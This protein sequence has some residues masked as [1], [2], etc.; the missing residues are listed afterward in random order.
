MV[1]GEEGRF[2]TLPDVVGATVEEILALQDGTL[3]YERGSM[4]INNLQNAANALC[5]TPVMGSC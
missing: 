2:Q 4:I 5:I 1:I 3:A